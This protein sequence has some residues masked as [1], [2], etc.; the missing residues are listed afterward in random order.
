VLAR[1]PHEFTLTTSY[2]SRTVNDGTGVANGRFNEFPAQVTRPIRLPGK[3]ALDREIGQQGVTYA[4][5]MAED[6]RHQAAL[7]LAQDW[8]DWLGAAA[9]GES[10]SAGGEELRGLLASVKRRVALRDASA[11][12]E[13]QAAPR[14]A[15]RAQASAARGA[16]RWRGRL[17]AISPLPLPVAAPDAPRRSPAGRLMV[18]H[19]RSGP[20]SRTGRSRGLARQA[21]AQ[22]DRARKERT[23]DPSLGLRVFSEKGGME[24]GAAWSSRCRSAAATAPPRPTRP[25]RRPAPPGGPAG[26]AAQH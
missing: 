20:Q 12:E 2:A 9:G 8:W 26:C 3:A 4:S 11:L 15:R 19:D 16:K 7:L 23:G 25:V 17:T 22:A 5:N 13:D 6:A 24:K 18:L 14:W 21:D 10:R 1:G